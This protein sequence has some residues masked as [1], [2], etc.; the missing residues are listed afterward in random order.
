VRLGPEGSPGKDA[1]GVIAALKGVSAVFCVNDRIAAE[2]VRCCV[3]HGVRIPGD[4]AVAGYDNN[5]EA[6]VLGLTSV[7]QHF[8]RVGETAAAVLLDVIE[9]GADGPVHERVQSEV[10][11]RGSTSGE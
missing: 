1:D 4:L 3:R 11:V 8:E 10:I 6:Q 5:H 7:E 2:V 9:G